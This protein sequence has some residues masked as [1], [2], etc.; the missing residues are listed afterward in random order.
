MDKIRAAAVR[1]IDRF[2]ARASVEAA[3]RADEL[4]DSG[5]IQS[6]V[7]WQLIHREIGNISGSSGMA[8]SEAL[9]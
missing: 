6:R 9:Q 8:Q 4:L 2:G 7:R 1:F 5:D 3:Q